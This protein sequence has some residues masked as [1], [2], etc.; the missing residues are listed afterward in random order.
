MALIKCSECGKEFSDK[1]SACPNCACPIENNLATRKVVIEHKKMGF[2][3]S[4]V[5]IFIY[6][7]NK[8]VGKTK[9]GMTLELDVPIGKHNIYL[10]MPTDQASQ[11]ASNISKDGKDFIIDETINSV[12]ILISIKL[13]FSAGTCQIDSINYF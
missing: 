12:K 8:M 6:I 11:S 10:E 5:E 4:G 3:G 9:S 1:A 13:G 2:L 7:D